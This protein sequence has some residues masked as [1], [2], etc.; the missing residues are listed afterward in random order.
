MVSIPPPL[1]PFLMPDR[2]EELVREGVFA[3]DLPG[4]RSAYGVLCDRWDATVHRARDLD[5]VRLDERIGGEWSFIETLRH[6]IFFI[7]VWVG[8][9]IE[10]KPTPNH[11]W[12]M[13]PDFLP[14]A[15]VTAMGLTVDA[16][17]SL[18]EVL[19]VLDERRAQIAQVLAR[20]TP[21]GL[22]RTCTPRGGQFRVV[23]ALQVVLFETWAHHQYA[24][25]DL[26]ILEQ[27]SSER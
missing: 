17:P 7:D 21:D 10:E 24:T 9:V 6:L 1:A 14:A 5:A 26:A 25:R 13:P 27:Q 23:G 3:D 15:A 11:P 18:D 20:L 4:I 8:D 19:A 16:R 22:D 2:A 12:G